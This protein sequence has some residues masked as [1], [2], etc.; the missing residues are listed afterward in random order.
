[1][2]HGSK[3]YAAKSIFAFENIHPNCVSYLKFLDI[4]IRT[5]KQAMT[6]NVLHSPPPQAN[7]RT[8]P[9]VVQRSVPFI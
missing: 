4:E 2:G 1:V 9:H 8:V 3:F 6:G 5:E 7:V